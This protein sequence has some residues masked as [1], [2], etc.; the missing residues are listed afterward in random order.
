MAEDARQSIVL[1]AEGVGK[2]PHKYMRGPLNTL[3]GDGNQMF[4]DSFTF[5]YVHVFRC[6]LHI[7]CVTKITHAR[8]QLNIGNTFESKSVTLFHEIFITT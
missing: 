8:R 1:S 3:T 2:P 7:T 4:V 5:Y 6:V